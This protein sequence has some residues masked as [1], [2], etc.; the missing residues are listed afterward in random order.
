MSSPRLATLSWSGLAIFCSLPFGAGSIAAVRTDASTDPACWLFTSGSG[1]PGGTFD[2]CVPAGQTLI[3]DTASTILTG[4]PHCDGSQVQNVVGGMI[5]ARNV[6]IGPGAVLRVIGPNP[7]VVFASG[8]VRIEGTID[9][10]GISNPGVAMPNAT[11]LSER[12]APGQAG[13]GAGGTGNPETTSP[14]AQG[15]NGFGAYGAVDRGGRGGETGWNNVS[16]WQLEGRRGAGGGGGAFGANQDQT[17]GSVAQF[18][19]WDQTFIGLDAEDGFANRHR[20]AQGAITG[21]E[22]PM[23]GR[24]G[25][26]PFADGDPHNDFYGY[27]LAPLTG[28]IVVGELETPWAGAGG[29]AGG[30]ASFVGAGGTWPPP[31]NPTEDEKGAGGGGGGGSLEILALGDIVFGRT[32]LIRCRGGDG[33][34]GESTLFLNR[35]GGSSG[36]GSG[37]HVILQ[38][39]GVIDFR[40]SL[41]P[42]WT[43]T[44]ELA[45]GILAT[46]G[47]GG[48]NWTGGIFGN[49]EDP[50]LP[51]AAGLDTCPRGYPEIGPNACLGHADGV[52]GDGGPGIVQLHTRNGFGPRDPSI[53]LPAGRTIRDLC[54]PLPIGSD[55]SIVLQPRFPGMPGDEALSGTGRGEQRWQESLRLRPGEGLMQRMR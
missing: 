6:S 35:V 36:G 51:N 24:V 25:P 28:A 40:S 3:V 55:G 14:T 5:E 16:L 41:G 7:L 33:G 12:G 10:S 17:F 22:G 1:G 18:G 23:G 27:G 8:T 2:W 31:F 46:G 32:G 38:T 49:Q 52:G 15:G 37:G 50:A 11:N 26:R 47:Q 9:V 39:A 29:G 54:K 45:G 43:H 44:G 34:W 30:N 4:G 42:S 19:L 48:G 53:L 13:G 20:E 21:P